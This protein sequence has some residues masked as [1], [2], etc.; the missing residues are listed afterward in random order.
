M[1]V[2]AIL[3]YDQGNID[4][5]NLLYVLVSGSDENVEYSK[6]DVINYYL[7][8]TIPAYYGN[9]PSAFAAGISIEQYHMSL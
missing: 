2:L 3:A 7:Y 5:G 9:Y 8:T 1:L 4:T 6:E